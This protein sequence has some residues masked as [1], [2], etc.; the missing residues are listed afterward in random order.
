MDES[1]IIVCTGPPLCLLEGNAAVANA[2]AGCPLCKHIRLEPDGTE[3]EYSTKA[4]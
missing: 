4:N 3:T 2:E 1:E